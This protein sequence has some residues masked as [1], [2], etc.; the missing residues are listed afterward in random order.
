[1]FRDFVKISECKGDNHKQARMSVLL[2]EIV[3]GA[4]TVIQ[5]T[6]FVFHESR[7]GSTL[8]ANFLASDPHSM[9][10]SESGPIALAINH[11]SGCSRE[12]HVQAIR[13][14][15]TLMG[16]SPIHKRLFFKFQS[17]T[18]VNMEM[19]LLVS[20]CCIVCQIVV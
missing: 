12:K 18:S 9:V 7:V 3:D 10:F 8:V 6:G 20:L 16:R 19:A 1:M 15:A 13:D 11:C 4:E 17:I 14:V 5:P 2:K